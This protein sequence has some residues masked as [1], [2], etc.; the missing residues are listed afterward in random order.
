MNIESIKKEIQKKLNQLI[1][2]G[3]ETEVTLIK[4]QGD[5]EQLGISD[6]GESTLSEEYLIKIINMTRASD[7]N[8]VGEIQNSMKLGDN[9][10]TYLEFIK[11]PLVFD[12]QSEEIKIEVGNRIKYQ[13]EE[14]VVFECIP[15][16][17]ENVVLLHQ[18]TA[19]KAI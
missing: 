14:Y 13:Q 9:P 16:V 5:T 4:K 7:K 2:I 10:D 17:L 3:L 18:Y 19:K 8:A 15:I 12:E 6:I 11:I 1:K